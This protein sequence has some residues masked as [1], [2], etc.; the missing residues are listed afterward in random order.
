M[1]SWITSI[2]QCIANFPLSPLSNDWN[3]QANAGICS[4]S[5][6]HSWLLESSWLRS[7]SGSHW[8]GSQRF[9]FAYYLLNLSYLSIYNIHMFLGA[10]FS[11]VYI[12]TKKSSLKIA[13][14]QFCLSV[15]SRK[16]NNKIKTEL[17]YTQRI[18]YSYKN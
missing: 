13:A 10:N 15:L 11:T 9:T 16:W 2:P 18:K 4:C 1:N 3:S 17:L 14:L 5:M 8:Y 12:L 6:P 7:S